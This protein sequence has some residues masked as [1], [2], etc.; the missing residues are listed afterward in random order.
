MRHKFR[1]KSFAQHHIGIDGAACCLSRAGKAREFSLSCSCTCLC[2]SDRSVRERRWV[3]VAALQNERE[4]ETRDR[5]ERGSAVR[6]SDQASVAAKRTHRLDPNRDLSDHKSSQPSAQNLKIL[7]ATD[8]RE[9]AKAADLHLQQMMLFGLGCERTS[10]EW[11][12]GQT[13]AQ[14]SAEIDFV[15]SEETG[16]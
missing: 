7:S 8:L 2:G 11:F 16:A 15:L 4:E 10:E 9:C 13:F 12:E 5:A 14:R 3:L 1:R 6:G